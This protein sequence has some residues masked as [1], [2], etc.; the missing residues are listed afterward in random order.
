[1]NP[2]APVTSTVPS[3]GSIYPSVIGKLFHYLLN[4]TQ[5]TAKAKCLFTLFISHIFRY[6]VSNEVFSWQI[7][8]EHGKKRSITFL[9]K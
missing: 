2:V 3:L 7:S 1:M 8:M 4:C 5:F 9:A 6:L